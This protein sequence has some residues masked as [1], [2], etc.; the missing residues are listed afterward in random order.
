MS[1]FQIHDGGTP[2]APNVEFL[3]G[4]TGGAVPPDA[5]FTINILGDANSN[6]T[7]T[8]VPLTN[9]LTISSTNI[10]NGSGSTVGATTADIIT[11]A[12]GATPKTY[13]FR[14]ELVVFNSSTPAGG[15]YQINATART[16]GGA[17]A[18]VQVPDGDEDEEAAL[19]NA[20]WDVIASANNIILRVTGAAGLTLNW[21]AQGY[22]IS[23]S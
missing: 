3:S 7:V 16:T 20:D 21:V 17:G 14:F 10:L 6:L 15:G 18:I 5:A 23:A 13:K 12:L 11:F 2:G 9:T 4:N 22:Y 1:Y 8:G 19:I